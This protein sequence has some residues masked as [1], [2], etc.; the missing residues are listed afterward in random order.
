MT[1]TSIAPKAKITASDSLKKI[2]DGL[3]Y[4]ATRGL[5]QIP[6]D[7][8]QV[9]KTVQD[10]EPELMTLRSLSAMRADL[11]VDLRAAK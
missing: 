10:Y 9:I 3:E 1:S 2:A 6:A 11:I 4:L 7:L 8:H 5:A